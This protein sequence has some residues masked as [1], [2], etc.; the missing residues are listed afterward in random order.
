[1]VDTDRYT[2][3]SEECIFSKDD[4]VKILME[5]PFYFRQDVKSRKNLVNE[6]MILHNPSSVSYIARG[7]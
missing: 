5:S 6:F 4:T 3:I 7:R 1:M 2:D